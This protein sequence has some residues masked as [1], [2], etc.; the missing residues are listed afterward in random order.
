MRGFLQQLQKCV[1]RHT[2]RM[3]ALFHPYV[4]HLMLGIQHHIQELHRSVVL[5][6]A[7]TPVRLSCSV[8]VLSRKLT[9]KAKALH[10]SRRT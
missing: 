4:K 8:Q 2:S 1:A 10:A 5:H 9:L 6:A 3:K 7:A